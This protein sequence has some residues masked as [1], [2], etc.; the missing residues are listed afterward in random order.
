MGASEVPRRRSLFA[1]DNRLLRPMRILITLLGRRPSA[2][3]GHPRY[4]QPG[5]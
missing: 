4:R 3:L 1:T 2:V 5:G